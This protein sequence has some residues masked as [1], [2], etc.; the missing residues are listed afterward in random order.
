MNLRWEPDIAFIGAGGNNPRV[1][2]F[3]AGSPK[4][5]KLIELPPHHS[6]YA[7]DL[8]WEKGLL[9]IGTKGGLIYVLDGTQNQ[10]LGEAD[11]IHKMVQ[12][13]PVL[14]VCWINKDILAVSDTAGRCFL[15]YMNTEMPP[16]HLESVKGVI[17]C[18][19]IFEDGILAGLS[20]K[21]TLHF[22]HPVKGQ[23]IRTIDVPIPPPI[24]ALVQMVYWPSEGTL[25]FPAQKGCLTVF[26]IST[27]SIET[28]EAH[29]GDVY[30]I[31]VWEK[32]LMAA[33]MMDGRLKIWSTGTQQPD[34][35]FQVPTGVI[36]MAATGVDP[37]QVLLVESEG[38]VGVFAFEQNRLQP[39]KR[40]AGKGYRVVCGLSFGRIKIYYDQQRKEKACQ[41]K[42]EILMKIGREPDEVIENYHSKLKDLGFEHISLA[43]R[44]EQADAKEDIVE[45]IR[46]RSSLVNMLPQDDPNSFSSMEKYASLLEKAGHIPE[47]YAIYQH[48]LGIDPNYPLNTQ[49]DLLKGIVDLLY[50]K[51]KWVIDPDITINQIIQSSTII[52]KKFAGRY[53]FKKLKPV[54]CGQA[55]ISSGLIAKKY[56]QIRLE[57]GN[58]NLPQV[59]NEQIW[60]ISRT[61]FEQAKLLTFSSNSNN[62]LKG[63]QFAIEVINNGMGIMVIPAILFDWR[64]T[65]LN[66]IIEKENETA[67]KQLAH[68][69]KSASSR[70]YIAATHKMIN[71]A[72]RRLLTE[73]TS[74]KGIN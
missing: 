45:S 59:V 10:N 30:A 22:W 7:M 48:I 9:A 68:I 58:K 2:I 62:S 46:I 1:E 17:C 61:K 3:R 15:W 70:P 73:N 36:S 19:L 51:L 60:W 66:G 74:R 54:Q 42:N 27:E 21:G 24:S 8:Q 49:I 29:K 50:D 65:Q 33:G 63:L 14:S 56:E 12:G 72:L 11:Q 28:I 31:S 20:T 47:A 32:G 40:L 55:I 6:A 16:Q 26:N 5:I 37:C 71:Q 67:S 43:L 38:T 53:L 25:V 69:L 34:G 4:S 39:V 52:G 35:E 18:L 41:L 13:A 44:A 57:S 64:D 23:L